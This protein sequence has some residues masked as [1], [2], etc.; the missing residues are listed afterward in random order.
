MS[1][2][3]R[4]QSKIETQ[5]VVSDD[6]TADIERLKADNKDFSALVEE[7]EVLWEYDEWSGWIKRYV[8]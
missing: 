4:Q 6:P 3:G 5:P 1:A 2:Y 8:N 7:H